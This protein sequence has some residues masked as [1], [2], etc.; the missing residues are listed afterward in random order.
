MKSLV[1]ASPPK[2]SRPARS[3]LYAKTTRFSHRAR[4]AY[5][6]AVQAIRSI[7]NSRFQETGDSKQAEDAL[8]DLKKA[9]PWLFAGGRKRYRPQ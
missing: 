6:E 2:G 7:Y 1:P 4:A 5:A 8:S 9:L 3:F